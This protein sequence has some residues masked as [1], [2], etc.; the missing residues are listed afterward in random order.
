MLQMK[1]RLLGH[2]TRY[3]TY[4]FVGDSPQSLAGGLHGCLRQRASP[5]LMLYVKHIHQHIFH[6]IHTN[7]TLLCT[8]FSYMHLDLSP[9]VV[10]YQLHE[11][12][13]KA[14]L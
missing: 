9:A 4:Q 13:L 10:V 12:G 11:R 2:G 6:R 1:N 14:E 8:I 5:L 3:Y 7:S